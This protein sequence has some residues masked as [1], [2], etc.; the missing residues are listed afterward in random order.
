MFS[1][2]ESVFISLGVGGPAPQES[3]LLPAFY[4]VPNPIEWSVGS[5]GVFPDLGTA[6]ASVLVVDGD[7]LLLAAEIFVVPA[8]INVAKRVQIV[9]GGIGLTVL[10]ASAALPTT[11]LNIT[12]AEVRVR[13]L[14][15]INPHTTGAGIESCIA[16]SNVAGDY[17]LE[18]LGISHGEFGITI[19]ARSFTIRNVQTVYVGPAA[20]TN[21]SLGVYGLGGGDALVEDFTATSGGG[22][23]RTIPLFFSGLG[24]D[25]YAGTITLRNI[26]QQG[27]DLV[28][29]FMV[30]EHFVGAAGALS[31]ELDGATIVGEQNGNV[32]FFLGAAGDLALF[33]SIT[34]KNV[35][36][37]NGSGKGL[38]GLD[39]LAP[40]AAPTHAPMRFDA[41]TLAN[42]TVNAV[43]WATAIVPDEGLLGYNTAI[44]GSH[45]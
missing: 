10:D 9:G 36:T 15:V 3:L 12:N 11:V 28:R 7:T 29:Q 42:P 44:W 38:V 30:Q 24:G 21:R 17:V 23:N 32:I 4:N 16:V 18:N 5:A 45:P 13:D 6:L 39:A 37:P 43:G 41:N 35:T 8:Q 20:N 1:M 26:V 22:N 40:L 33:S 2:A 19:R 25:T 14:T 31:L 34:I 27:A